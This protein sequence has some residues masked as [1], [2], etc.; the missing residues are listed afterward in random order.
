[1]PLI[2]VIHRKVEHSLHERLNHPQHADQQEDEAEDVR[3]PAKVASGWIS[4]TIPAAVIRT[5]TMIQSQ[6]ALRS[7]A[8]SANSS[9]ANNRNISPV[10]TPTVT[11]EAWLNFNTTTAITSHSTPTDRSIHQ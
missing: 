9:A 8:A 4:A 7:S 11:T 2:R 6:R 3:D 5:P 10:S 1:M